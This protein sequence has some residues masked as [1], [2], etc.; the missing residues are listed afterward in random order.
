MTISTTT[1]KN[2]HTG[3]ASATTFAYNFKI[4]DDDDIEVIK[5]LADGTTTTLTKS[6]HYTVAGVGADSGSVTISGTPLAANES[7]TLNRKMSFTQPTDLQ[8]QGGFFAEVHETA[9]D[10]QAM[11]ALQSQEES[12]RSLKLPTVET[13]DMTLPSKDNRKGKILGFHATTGAP[14]ASASLTSVNTLAAITSSI[15]TVAGIASN[16]TA[17]ANDATDIGVVA[18]KATE[19][20]RLGTSDAVAD[21][22]ILGTNAV[23]ADMAILGTNDVV[24]DMA[25]LAT[26][27]VVTDMNVL[28]T[29]DVVTDMNLLATST[30]VGNMN[31]LG[32]AAVVEDMGL[33]GTAAVVADLALLGTADVVADMALLATSDVISDMNALATSDIISD[34]NTLATS[35]IVTDMNLLA[36]SAN[37]TAMGTLGTSANV[38]AISTV[39]GAIAN[40]NTTASNIAGVN[41]F[42][43]RYRIA[44]SE[45]SSD[46]DEGDLYYN[47][48]SNVL[49]FYN[50][51]AWVQLQN[52][53]H[54][55]HSGEVTSTAD[56]ATVIAGDVVDEANLKVSNDPSNGYFLSAQS[57]NTG[58]MTWAEVDA[59]PSQTSNSGK[60]LT[61]NG[62]AASW[63]VLDTDANTTTKGLYEHA[64][65]IAANYSITSGNNAMTAGPITINTG[66]S[67]TVPSGSTWVIA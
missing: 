61:T 43:A 57:G 27:D 48:S 50:G 25:I 5:T 56:G 6:T 29:S 33:L 52:Y 11:Y 55:N 51:S 13:L 31:L 32:T 26:N 63:A 20:G 44:S 28:G 18:G 9:F 37:V 3:N 39:S 8:N 65:T 1:T 58:G 14:E 17:V 66:I 30:V 24:A 38:T 67:V 49:F 46:L 60:Y 7:V 21:M 19:I 54:P 12:A 40:V 45:P 36:T 35:D 10:R 47:T 23:V 59:L 62:S 34:L 15:T 42:A 4:L 16:V 22:A 53:T 64:H 2:S 41:S